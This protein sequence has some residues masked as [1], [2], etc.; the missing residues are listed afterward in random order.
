MGH[1]DE[2]GL[3]RKTGEVLASRTVAL[4]LFGGICVSGIPLSLQKMPGGVFKWVVNA[5]MLALGLNIAF[6]T[7]RQWRS[8]ATPV[9]MLHLGLLVVI[10]GGGLSET[11]YIGTANIY[12]GDM[13][14]SFYRWDREKEFKPGYSVLLRRIN[15]EYY[16][17]WVKVGVKH[18]G[19]KEA[20]FV[21]RTGDDF[22]IGD[23]TVRVKELGLN[24]PHLMM[25]VYQAGNLVGRYNTLNST[26]LSG[27]FPYDFVLV[28]YTTPVISR[29]SVDLS[30]IGDD[31]SV[32]EGTTEVNRPFVWKGIR[33]F[34]TATSLDSQGRPYAGIQVVYDPG[35]PV[36]YAGFFILIAGGVMYLRRFYGHR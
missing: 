12:E 13:V 17:V 8:L 14:D 3:W 22:R 29:A 1:H 32:A 31:G 2:V 19:K 33:F 16:P 34:H 36:V 9:T 35:R 7:V 18:N 4:L 21:L 24:P 6:C 23:Y 28:A 20:L 10:A 30:V 25:D 27:D 5:L 11:G 15:I 26:G